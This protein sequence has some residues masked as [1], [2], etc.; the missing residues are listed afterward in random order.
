[1]KQNFNEELDK[2][3]VG[4]DKATFH[5]LKGSSLQ[6]LTQNI[7]IQNRNNEDVKLKLQH[8]GNVTTIWCTIVAEP[9][10]AT[11]ENLQTLQAGNHQNASNP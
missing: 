7:F 3:V 6:N 10:L 1:M 4:M 5:Y 9:Y 11:M 2:S 8:R